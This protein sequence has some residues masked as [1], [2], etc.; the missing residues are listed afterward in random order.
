MIRLEGIRKV[1]NRTVAVDGIDLEVGHGEFLT[2]IGPSG[3]GKSTTLSIV[4]G[5]QTPSSGS[6]YIDGKDVTN[7]PPHRRGTP[8]VWQSFVLFPHMSV[9]RNIEYGLKKRAVPRRER[10]ERV[11]QMATILGIREF[12]NRGIDELSGGQ[13]QRVGLARAM[14]LEP[15]VLLLDEPLG[16]LDAN[17]KVIMQSELKGLQQRFGITFLYV[18]HNQSEALA[19]ADRIAVMNAGRIEQLGTGKELVHRPRTKFVAQFMG[20]NNVFDGTVRDANGTHVEVS[21]PL[22]SLWGLMPERRTQDGVVAYVVNAD[23]IKMAPTGAD[24]ALASGHANTM[25][26]SVAG[27]VKGEEYQGAFTL[28]SVEVN[29]HLLR[30]SIPSESRPGLGDNVVLTWFGGDALVIPVFSS[31][32]EHIHAEGT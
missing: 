23:A 28:I 16:S 20:R 18:T 17:L 32:W 1:F 14:V 12:L 31:E 6:V 15:K 2:L 3:C 8:M 19:M 7:T 27:T 25:V 24:A 11:E 26:N 22:G 5:L 29:G 10:A 9:F 21:C 30:A 4:A 13:Q